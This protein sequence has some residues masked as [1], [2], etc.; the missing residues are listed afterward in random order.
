MKLV[1][2]HVP[3]QG[4]TWG[5]AEDDSVYPLATDAGSGG[6]F[7]ASLLQWPDPVRLLTET[8]D[9]LRGGAAVSLVELSAAAAHPGV[10]HL[11][12]PI[13]QQEVWA[14]GVTYLRSKV[15]RME[16]SEGAARFYDLVYDAER[17]ELFLKATPS[18]VSGQNGPV[19][20][21]TDARWNVPEPEVGLLLTPAMK[22]V[23]YTVGNDMSS[24]DIEG[25]NPLY[26]PQAKVYRDCC[27]LGPV[28]WLE[29]EAPE[30]RELEIHL[31]IERGN[32]LVFSGETSTAQMKRKFAE[33][34]GWL[35][36]D[37]HFPQGAVLLTG[38]GLVPSDEFTLQPGDVVAISVPQIGTLMNTVVQ[39]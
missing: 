11:L 31:A 30:H 34:A 7:L 13:D 15:A 16:E 22:C 5:L 36:K 9:T 14:A 8:F 10:A 6:A 33:L 23:G 17:P 37:N 2:Y 4:G 18:R 24:R 38:T 26:L 20:I 1:H 27:A 21:R 3:G 39:G 35:G 25:E 29:P 19:R 12:P 32:E 28:I